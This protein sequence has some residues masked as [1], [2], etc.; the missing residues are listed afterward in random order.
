MCV[1]FAPLSQ[2]ASQP[3]AAQ[4]RATI[5]PLPLPFPPVGASHFAPLSAFFS[6]KSS[7]SPV[8]WHVFACFCNV[9]LESTVIYTFVAIRPFQN[10]IFYNVSNSLVSPN[11]WKRR[12]LHCV[13]QLF[14]AGQ[15]KHICK[16]NKNIVFYSVFTM[17][18]VENTVIYTFFGIKSVQNT[19]F[20]SVFNALASKNPS[21]PWSPQTLENTAIYTV[22]FNFSMFQCRWSTRTYIQKILRTHCFLK[23]V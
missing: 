21:I 8:F 16:K 20:G 7:K 14:H 11:P 3:S 5:S 10:I 9:F 18:S 22:F 19:G 6:T 23:C 17:F 15:L 13:L 4:A 2:K 1:L 12:Y